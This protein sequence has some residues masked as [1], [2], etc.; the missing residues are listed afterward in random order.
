MD[1]VSNV[2]G[3][4]LGLFKTKPKKINARTAR[5]SSA[6]KMGANARA[7]GPVKHSS[8]RSASVSADRSS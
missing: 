3:Q 1:R 4:A 6:R 8:Y 7:G 5:A 2:F